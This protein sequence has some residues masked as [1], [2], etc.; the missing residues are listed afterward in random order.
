[1]SQLSEFFFGA[2]AKTLTGHEVD[3]SVSNGHEFQGVN[4]LREIFGD[5]RRQFAAKFIWLD[6]EDDAAVTTGSATWY[7]SRSGQPKRSAEFRLYYSAEADE[8]VHRAKPGDTMVIG[9][10]TRDGIVVVLCPVG[11][12][13][14]QQLL[15]LFGLSLDAKDLS[16][17]NDAALGAIE[18][19]LAARTVLDAIGIELPQPELNWIDRLTEAFGDSFP[20]TAAFSAFARSTIPDADAVADSDTALISIVDREYQLFR[21]WEK[22]LLSERLRTGFVTNGDVD[23]EA[24]LSVSLS[25]NQRRKSRAGRSLE[26]HL[27]WIFKQNGLRF[28]RNAKTEREKQPDF[29]FPGSIAYHDMAFS[30]AGLT[31]LGAKSTCKDRWRQVL[32]EGDRVREKH[33]LTLEPAISVN[34]TSEMR[35]AHLQLVLPKSIHATYKPVQQSWLLSVADFVRLVRERQGP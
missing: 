8:I 5:G 26:N 3:P 24:F 25:V 16:L 17:S 7:D 11:S 14:E 20:D 4:S 23:V 12:S 34:Q 21:V 10:D 31:L 9:K 6:D 2:V 13:T 29:L 15:W 18:T 22:H 27:T 32:S 28:E 33:L 19:G 1:M 30:P 35:N